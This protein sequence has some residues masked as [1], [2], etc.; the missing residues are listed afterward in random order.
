MLRDSKPC[1]KSRTPIL[2]RFRSL[3]YRSC[4]QCSTRETGKLPFQTGPSSLKSSP[5]SR[6]F[7][8]ILLHR[9]LKLLAIRLL[10]DFT[11]NSYCLYRNDSREK[12]GWIDGSN[13]A[14][15]E[16]KDSTGHN[17]N[18]HNAS[19]SLRFVS[20]L[21][22]LDRFRDS[23]HSRIQTASWLGVL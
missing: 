22:L 6:L 3:A 11:S 21:V 20:F 16:S 4:A 7:R 17:V 19:G 10:G 14:F 8:D 13:H 18:T 12:A 5:P 2:I 9:R 1:F 23:Q 15:H